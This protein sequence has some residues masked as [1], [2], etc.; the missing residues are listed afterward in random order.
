VHALK[1]AARLGVFVL[2]TSELARGAYRS[3]DPTQR[4]TS[5]A[6]FKE[7]GSVEYG[8][9]FA[10]VLRSVTGEADLVDVE[11]AKN[12]LG[13][14]LEF[15]LRLD[16]VRAL[17][18]EESAPKV[19]LAAE[20]E[21]RLTRERAVLREAVLAAVRQ[22]PP[23]A[24]KEAL[25]MRVRHNRVTTWRMLSALIEEGVVVLQAGA[26]RVA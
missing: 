21:E 16:R 15:R 5:L 1:R 13:A 24:G 7:S 19:D 12:R 26:Y 20:R 17:F 10:L 22:S 25:C 18:S 6:S 3:N 2:A 9:D 23:L 14:K 8:V 4:T 11:I